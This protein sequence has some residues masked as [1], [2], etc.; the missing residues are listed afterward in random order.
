MALNQPIKDWTGRT[1]W[2]VGASTGIGR[3]LAS[4][5]HARG[6]RVV[7]SA[8]KADALNAF[9]AEHPGALALPMDVADL[10]SV[11]AATQKILATACS[12]N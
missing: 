4:A 12:R 3:A 8:R 5:L 7:V 1:A 6:A 9:V 10:P 11:K 2:L